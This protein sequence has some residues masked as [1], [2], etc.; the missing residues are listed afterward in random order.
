MHFA[1]SKTIQNQVFKTVPT[2]IGLVIS[3]EKK[4]QVFPEI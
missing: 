4:R 1:P 2:Q 3:D